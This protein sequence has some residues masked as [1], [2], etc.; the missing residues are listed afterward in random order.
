[1]TI[2]PPEITAPGPWRHRDVA[3]NGARFHVAECGDGPLVLLLHGFPTFWWTWRHHLPLLA[4]SGYRAVAMDLRGYGG[5]DKT[6]RGYDPFTLSADVAGVV[7]S[8]G[9]SDAVVVGHGWGGFLAWTTAALHPE[10]VRGLVPVSMPHPRRLR[11]ALLTDRRQLA[12]S[13]YVFGFQRPWA[14]ENR[15]TADQ[16][17]D[18]ERLMRAWSG[19][20]GWP[21]DDT[22]AVFRRAFAM[23]GVV[24][25]AMEYYRWAL[26]SVPRPDGLRFASRLRTPVCAPVLHVLG[27]RDPAMLPSTSDGSEAF[28]TGRYTRRVLDT[29]H[30]VHEEAPEAFGSVLR[31][32]LIDTEH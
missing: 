28:V 14:P 1:M 2:G 32:W 25:S 13:A 18:V 5:S 10:V 7:R 3:A 20:P 26:R 27:A 15:L 11:T 8:L 24:H 29:G 21:D 23:P 30:F 17:A 6:P 16:A 19:T 4:D 31:G 22:A 12:A 9:S